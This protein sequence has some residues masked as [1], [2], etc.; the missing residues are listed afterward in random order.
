MRVEEGHREADHQH[1]DG[2]RAVL[3]GYVRALR[4][5]RLTAYRLMAFVGT[6]VAVYAAITVV[7]VQVQSCYAVSERRRRPWL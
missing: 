3:R 1:D 2:R 5:R 6:V 7:F 4:R